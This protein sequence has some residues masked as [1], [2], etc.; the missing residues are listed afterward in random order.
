VFLLILT[1]TSWQI[2]LPLWQ[3]FEFGAQGMR[4]SGWASDG[5]WAIQ[6]L[7]ELAHAADVLLRKDVS[8]VFLPVQE[9]LQN[10]EKEPLKQGK[11]RCRTRRTAASGA[12]STPARFA[13]RRGTG[14]R[15]S[16]TTA[17]H[18]KPPMPTHT[19]M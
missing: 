14:A 12:G 15:S 17:A 19:H 13:R 9:R 6:G 2:N 16:P 3:R 4:G 10:K 5:P 1:N 8:L 7:H 11:N 18:Q